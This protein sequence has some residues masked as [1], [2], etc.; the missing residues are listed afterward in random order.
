MI[1]M[2]EIDF[3]HPDRQAEFEAWYESHLQRIVA[4][5]GFISAQRFKS[6]GPAASSNLAIYALESGDVLTSAPYRAK[7]GPESV[8]VLRPLFTN[9]YR[10]LLSGMTNVPEVARDGWIAVLDRLTETA[11]AL[12]RGYTPLKPV[13][14]DRSIIERGL[15]FGEPGRTPPQPRTTSDINLRVFRP[16]SPRLLHPAA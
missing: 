16:V 6:T 14:L 9:W 13:G 11:P 1:Y 3:P 8:G 12:E 7:F 4:V 10:N 15:M 2:V 5:P